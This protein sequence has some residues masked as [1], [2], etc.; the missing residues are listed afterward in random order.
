MSSIHRRH[1]P[2]LNCLWQ[3][4]TWICNGALHS[5]CKLPLAVRQLELERRNSPGIKYEMPS[6]GSKT[7]GSWINLHCSSLSLWRSTFTFSSSD[8][9]FFQT[10]VARF[11]RFSHRFACNFNTYAF[12]IRYEHCLRHRRRPHC[13]LSSRLMIV[14]CRIFSTIWRISDFEKL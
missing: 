10:N 13:P 12:G 2:S 11:C 14:D 6:V 1:S 8:R 5:S 3:Q 9:D 4:D 7:L